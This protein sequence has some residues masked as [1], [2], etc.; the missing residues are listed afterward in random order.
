MAARHWSD[1]GPATAS[2]EEVL[3]WALREGCVVFTHDLDFSRLL[4]LTTA[5]GPSV[6]QLRTHDVL[7]DR[8]APLVTSV[9]LEHRQAL[10]DGALVV[11]DPR[12]ARVRI[13]PLKR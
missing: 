3:D 2:D 4:A 10:L 6:V 9:L 1:V 7:P 5:A 13:L 11:I 12:G 8:F